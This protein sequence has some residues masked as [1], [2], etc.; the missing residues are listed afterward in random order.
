MSAIASYL[1]MDRRHALWR[2]VPLAE[3]T[4]G[5]VLFADIAGFTAAT[6]AVVQALGPQRGVETL[7]AL[8]NQIYAVLNDE[9]DRYGGSVVGFAGDALTVW[10][11][12]ASP[13]SP[14]QAARRAVA[15]GLAMHAGV[16]PL[17]SAQLPGGQSVSFGLKTT[18]ASGPIR[19]LLV[20][21][22]A[23]QRAEVLAG[24]TIVRMA[25][26]AQQTRAGELLIDAPS[27]ELLGDEVTL[28]EWRAHGQECRCA[29]VGALRVAVAAQPWPALPADALSHAQARSWL[30]PLVY[31]RLHSGRDD[32]LT[33]LRHTVSLFLRFT[34]LDYDHDAQAGARLD[35]FVRWVQRVVSPYEGWLMQVCIGDKG[36]YLHATFG[37][38][39][40]H[41]DDALRAVSAALELGAPP[42]DL[43]QIDS[44]QIGISAG[45]SLA[46][47]VGGSTRTYA[48]MGDS[49]NLAARLM[50]AASPGQV[51]ISANLAIAVSRRYILEPLPPIRVKG[52][53]EAVP[54]MTITGPHRASLH[55]Q[56]PQ[57]ALPM[58]GRGDA[59][60]L[61]EERLARAR[62]GS[63]QIISITGE[64]GQGKSRLVAEIIRRATAAGFDGFGG[65]AQLTST[66]VP[67]YAWQPI[68]LGFFGLDPAALF[69]DQ[70]AQLNAK[71]TELG[72]E[73][74]PRMPLLSVV[75]GLALE[76]N[77][78]T[79]S[80]DPKQRKE[81][82]ETLLAD[83]LRARFAPASPPASGRS[84]PLLL[85]LEDAHWLGTLSIDLLA[86]LG[87]VIERLPVLL[88]LACRH[89][90]SAEP[91]LA[92]IERLPC[93]TTVH[94][95]ELPRED[96]VCLI[97]HKIALA[98]GPDRVLPDSFVDRII[99]LS[100]GNPFHI[101]ELLNYIHAQGIALSELALAERLELPD[102]LAS[103]ILSR[104]DQLTTSQQHT[105]K[106][107]S[108]IGRII[109]FSWLWGVYPNLGAE[110]WVRRDMDLLARMD[111]TPLY[112]P[113]PELSYLFR[114]ATM[115]EVVYES[116]PFALRAQLHEQ[117]GVWLEH[118]AE[119]MVPL[120][121]LAYHYGRS[122]NRPKQIE[123]C[124]K[125]AEAA[126]ARY[127]NSAAI[128]YYE[129]L[130]E[131]LPD[132]EHPPV[133]LALGQV[134]ERVSAWEQAEARY[135]A[136]LA[137]PPSP[138]VTPVQAHAR[139]G[140]SETLRNRGRYAEAI[141]WLEGA[142]TEFEAL[143]NQGE[144]SHTLIKLS[145]VYWIL[146]D[147]D[148]AQS[149]AEQ[150]LALEGPQ[151]NKRRIAFALQMVGGAALIR[152][153][154]GHAFELWS[155]SL[156]IN[157]EIGHK[158][159]VAA[160]STTLAMIAFTQNMLDEGHALATE[161][162]MLFY[163]LGAR[164]E[165]ALA[166]SVLAYILAAQGRFE[167][168]REL[169]IESIT[170]F[171]ALGA[172]T[173][174]D[175]ALLG[176]AL[177]R[178][179]S[180]PSPSAAYYAVRL[181]RAGEQVHA[182]SNNKRMPIYQLTAD[183]LVDLAR[184]RLAHVA[185]EDAWTTGATLSWTEAVEYALDGLGAQS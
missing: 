61:I 158:M 180:D 42:D 21:D 125:A 49:V 141:S 38:P 70:L 170:S 130:L 53:F 179:L 91:V 99:G 74:L 75:L 157:R 43:Y 108:V 13:A 183:R 89:S 3:H 57:Y 35:A 16:C 146:G 66:Q 138:Q 55:L 78:L 62:R 148:R 136:L 22:P 27:A 168:A 123:Y 71:L 132:D 102:S 104:I 144:V 149:V 143:G 92:A 80:M 173:V 178:L 60:A 135:Q 103:L 152:S 14:A 95:A 5:A 94:L 134:L 52:K 45:Q 110:D 50:E 124:R 23:V 115:Q 56:E 26:V 87:R 81:Y 30:P 4:V 112:T 150:S 47:A 88:V 100:E 48:V 39:I 9:I 84:A 51:L 64:A 33:E 18:I 137:L 127:A 11:D 77:A 182:A 155:Q 106:V 67:Y 177:L 73:L 160:S 79:S 161:S 17:L 121:L 118:Q 32:F 139:A 63:G 159:G 25:G 76:D 6:E 24:A 114:H 29:M 54:V 107:A 111:I 44:I 82:L 105:L 97:E 83:C 85:V 40:A 8:L 162:S 116:L 181:I 165:Y 37:A 86:A 90:G 34:D 167:R 140:V 68:W 109:R 172:V 93:Y 185:F 65:A 101:E 119:S 7:V 164:W 133:L 10:F 126:V 163:E 20:G 156:N 171:R 145:R 1:P 166:R 59:V 131:L 142:R 72:P 31:E 41:G 184:P 151:G 154:Y 147:A 176:M 58:I 96:A 113:E 19:R 46:G 120:D 175:T 28:E 98:F 12:G 36:S 174:I 128:Q 153:D 117:L 129:R 2:G 169:Q 122:P 15:C 69:E